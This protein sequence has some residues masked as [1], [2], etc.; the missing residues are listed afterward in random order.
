MSRLP[1]LRPMRRSIEA[2]FSLVELMIAV[3]IGLFIT[4]ALGAVFINSKS[5]FN[6]QDQ[7]A[8][9]QDGERLAMTLLT[10]TVQL[11]GYYPTPNQTTKLAQLPLGTAVPGSAATFS[12]SAGVV[13]ASNGATGDLLAT[14][15]SVVASD[16]QTSCLGDAPAGA[17]PVAYINVFSVSAGGD[18]QCQTSGGANDGALVSLVSGVASMTVMYGIDPTGT[19]NPTQYATAAGVTAANAWAG[20]KTAQI[21][22]N[23]KNPYYN[24]GQGGQAQTIPWVTT[25]SLMN[26][27]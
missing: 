8:Q 24:N 2:G 14:R 16:S 19:G 23:F 3:T 15:Y 13:G 1:V 11:A 5:A 10:S 22:I 20:V 17:T 9:L 4:A 12:A 27:N 26:S 25:V 6:S 21:T 18:L 7:L